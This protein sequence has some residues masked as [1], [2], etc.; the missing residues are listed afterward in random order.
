MKTLKIQGKESYSNRT[1][2]NM[3]ENNETSILF[4]KPLG[5][6]CQ[7]CKNEGHEALLCPCTECIYCKSGNHTSYYCESDKNKIEYN[8]CNQE[9]HTINTI[10]QL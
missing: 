6:H 2:T 3:L 9:G 7:I 1:N 8:L 5:I 10:R 4:S